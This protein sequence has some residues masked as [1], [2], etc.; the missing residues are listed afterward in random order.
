MNSSQLLN[1]VKSDPCLRQYVKG[2]FASNTLPQIITQYPSAFIVNTQPVP[3]PGEHW[4]ALIIYS[5]AQAEFFDSL[6]KSPV[7]CTM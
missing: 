1:M 2:V 7:Q 6:G 5:P 3:F 4:L